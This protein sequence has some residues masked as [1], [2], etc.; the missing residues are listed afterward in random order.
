MDYNS[1]DYYRDK[2]TAPQRAGARETSQGR[3]PAR[4]HRSF[5]TLSGDDGRR[6]ARATANRPSRSRTPGRSASSQPPK[7]SSGSG[8]RPPRK[9]SSFGGDSNW[10]RKIL[11]GA[12]LALSVIVIAVFAFLIRSKLHAVSTIPTEFNRPYFDENPR[13]TAVSKKN[14]TDRA[15]IDG[16]DDTDNDAI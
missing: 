11:Y 7:R 16:A 13:Y 9:P 6:I 15:D 2:L 10:N 8:G 4:A 1:A 12:L 5:Y 14:D 3:T